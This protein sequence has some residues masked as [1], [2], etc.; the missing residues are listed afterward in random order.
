M[1]FVLAYHRGRHELIERHTYT[2]AEHEQAWA[3]RNQL[4]IKHA[5]EADVE[6]VLLGADSESELLRT[7]GRYFERV[8]P[9]LP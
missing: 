9:T 3:Q 2:A 7:H 6:V 1:Y 8:A 4:T 5:G